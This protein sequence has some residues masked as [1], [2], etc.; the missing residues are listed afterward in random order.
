MAYSK[1]LVLKNFNIWL[2]WTSLFYVVIE[3]KKLVL[4]LFKI[5]VR[6][7]FCNWHTRIFSD[8]QICIFKTCIS[9]W[10]V[11]EKDTAAWSYLFSIYLKYL[12]FKKNV[13]SFRF[14]NSNAQF[15]CSSFKKSLHV[16]FKT[17]LIM[18]MKATWSSG[19]TTMCP[20]VGRWL[21]R[22]FWWNL[23]RPVLMKILTCMLNILQTDL[24][25]VKNRLSFPHTIGFYS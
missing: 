16:Y 24:W 22:N 2:T 5:N 23:K 19:A 25:T 15:I 3:D 14:S 13:K 12:R 9:N 4:S 21:R 6:T 18:S 11:Y 20:A 17:G 1:V 8:K 10:S 7:W